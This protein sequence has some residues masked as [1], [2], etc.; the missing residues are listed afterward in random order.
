MHCLVRVILAFFSPAH[1][2]TRPY[3]SK[4]D[5][6]EEAQEV[7][8]EDVLNFVKTT[9]RSDPERFLSY[10]KVSSCDCACWTSAH[11]G[12]TDGSVW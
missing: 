11:P 1:A 12:C 4:V 7:W 2:I 3:P 10:L 9:A 6:I 5:T 8:E